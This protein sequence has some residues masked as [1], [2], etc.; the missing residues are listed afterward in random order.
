VKKVFTNSICWLLCIVHCTLYISCADKPKQKPVVVNYAKLKEDIIQ[1][2]KPAVVMESDE[3]NAY[4]KAHNYGMQTTGTGLR[5]L[6]VKENPKEKKIEKGDRIKVK[7]K[8][9]LLDGT[10]CYSSDNKGLKEFTVGADDVEHGVHEGVQL[11]RLHDK[12]IFI[13][14]THLAFGL[15]GDRNKI[16][17]KSAVVY[18]VE[19][20]SIDEVNAYIRAHNYSMQ[21]TETGLWYTFLNENSKEEQVKKGDRIKVKYKVSLLDGTVCYTSDKK[22]LKEYTV[23]ANH[24]G[25]AMDEGVQLMHLYDRAIFILPAHMSFGLIEDKDKIPPKTVVVYEV[26][27]VS[28]E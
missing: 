1:V 23:G 7:Y 6:L 11:M 20:V 10:L 15:I 21:T 13:L 19:V 14:P 4:V 27:V 17:P 18:E 28:I 8:V 16:P 26:E 25:S 5:Y 24:A 2:N 3:I 9:S 22:S 12:A